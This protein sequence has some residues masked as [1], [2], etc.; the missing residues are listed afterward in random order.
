MGAILTNRKH[1]RCY[2]NRGIYTIPISE[3]HFKLS[4]MNNDLKDK[5]NR[6][7]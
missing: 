5:N 1:N 7:N 6:N 4:E 2:T 3:F